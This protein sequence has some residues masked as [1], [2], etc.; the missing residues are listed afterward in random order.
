MGSILKGFSL[1]R[2]YAQTSGL[3]K[4][5]A[6]TGKRMVKRGRKSAK[7]ATA[8]RRATAIPKS[9]SSKLKSSKTKSVRPKASAPKSAK[10]KSANSP[11]NSKSGMARLQGALR[12]TR[13]Q[14]SA[15]AEILKVINSSPGNL[16][17]V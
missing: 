1:D 3:A 13:N 11:K 7:R 12:A 6:G 5:F 9:T 2:H 10:S 8:P 14:Q 15:S 4:L 16:A 17:P